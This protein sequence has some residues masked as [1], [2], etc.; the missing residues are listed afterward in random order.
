MPTINFSLK[1]LNK[2]VG[3][4]LTVDQV[5][6]LVEFGKGELE[7]YDKETDELK[8]NFD[9]TNLPYLW[10]VEGAARL[11]RGVLGKSKGI[12]KL[13]VKKSGYKVIVDK[14]VKEVRPFISAFV[15]KGCKV[16]DYLIKQIIQLQEKLCESFGRKR[17]KAAVGVY[18]YDKI[19]FPVTYKATNPESVKFTPLEFFKEMKHFIKPQ[20]IEQG[21]SNVEI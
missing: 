18:A 21:I 4:K 5:D 1:D 9:D 16:D 2:L 6:H 7:G 20:N 12:P 3:E 8:V 10:S 19:T 11:I 15:A 14:S 13:E 17:Q